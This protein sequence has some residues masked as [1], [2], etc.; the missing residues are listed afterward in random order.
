VV[1]AGALDALD[2]SEAMLGELEGRAALNEES[3]V[4]APKAEPDAS[5]GR[6]WRSRQPRQAPGVDPPS[7]GPGA[8]ER[9]PSG[10]PG[11][12]PSRG[13]GA[14]SREE[15]PEPH[16]KNVFIAL[17]FDLPVGTI[18]PGGMA[19]AS[20]NL[21]LARWRVPSGNPAS[22]AMSC[23]PGGQPV[24]EDAI[25][26]IVREELQPLR[27]ALAGLKV[28]A[29]VAELMTAAEAAELARCTPETIRAWVHAGKLKRHGVN[30]RL[31]VRRD[32]LLA[33][34]KS[35]PRGMTEGELEAIANQVVE[36][37]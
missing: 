3:N 21:D 29:S 2:G 19:C 17:T 20:I 23:G 34:L 32:Q 22:S 14:S 35:E 28:P 18:L 13:T 4:S 10:P 25:R 30:G 11:P 12:F 27:E 5:P 36:G 26:A 8:A 37:R 33:L 16:H 9:T 1:L 7:P 6:G 24:F 31:L 15:M